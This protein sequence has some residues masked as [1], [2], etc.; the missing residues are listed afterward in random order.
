MNKIYVNILGLSAL[1]LLATGCSENSWNDHLEGFGVPT[2]GTQVESMTY[3]LTATDY[4]TISSLSG[5]KSIKTNL[6]FSS[7]AQAQEYIPAFLASS[8][9]TYFTLDNGS[10]IKVQYEVSEAPDPMISAIGNAPEYKLSE[11]DYKLVWGSDDD[12]IAALAPK[13]PAKKALPKVL[14]NAYPAAEAGDVVCVTYQ[15]TAANPIFGSIGGGDTPENSYTS[16][17]TSD[18][19]KDDE[20]TVKG[21]VTGISTRGFV[22]TDNAGSI[23]FDKS[24]F[25]QSSVS[26][27]SEVTCSGTVGVYSQCLQISINNSY[28][29]TGISSYQYPAP[30]VMDG[31]A[32]DAACAETADI[33]AKYVEIEATVSVSNNKYWNLNIEGA[34]RQGSVYNAPQSVKDQLPDGA[35]VKLNGYFVAVTGSARYFN[36]L[37]TSVTNLDAATKAPVGEMVSSPVYAVYSYNGTAWAPASGV[38]ALQAADYRQLQQSYDNLSNDLPAQLLPK[39]MDVNYPYA[40]EGDSKLI[41]Y[42]YYASS[43]TT[44]RV[45]SMVRGADGWN[46]NPNRTVIVDQFNKM[47]NTWKFDPSVKI[48]LLNSN[49][50]TV[51]FYQ[52]CVDWVKANAPDGSKYV[53]SYGNNDYYGGASAYYKNVDIRGDKAR[54]Q[55]AAGFEGMTDDQISELIKYRFCYEVIPGTL[56]TLYPDAKPVEGMEVLYTIDFIEYTGTSTNT[57]GVWKVTGPAKFEFVSCTWWTDGVSPSAK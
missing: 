10:S 12:F 17:I 14:A 28:E 55:Y 11:A 8:K 18:V 15:E 40:S 50:S 33:L 7:D 43:N 25:D 41:A 23:C 47:N 35:R 20:L 9:F 36:I 45:A 53:S 54:A 4:E 22:V 56:A 31:A 5:D 29:V 44:N 49:Q 52:A 46:F 37:V 30:V 42:R 51:D 34:T 21:V 24:G 32:V 19:K 1:A 2:P 38:T 13:T 3:T 39:F 26:I 16:V 27:G 48:D 6:C 57:T